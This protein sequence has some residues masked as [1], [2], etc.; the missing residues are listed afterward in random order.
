MS[1][2]DQHHRPGS[3]FQFQAQVVDPDVLVPGPLGGAP[4]HYCPADYFIGSTP[5]VACSSQMLGVGR[6][7]SGQTEKSGSFPYEVDRG[8]GGLYMARAGASVAAAFEPPR[9]LSSM[10]NVQRLSDRC[11]VCSL[12]KKS[13]ANALN[14]V[15]LDQGAGGHVH[16]RE[17][18]VTNN[19][20][21]LALNLGISF[22]CGG[23]PITSR[24]ENYALH[25]SPPAIDQKVEMMGLGKKVKAGGGDS[26]LM[27]YEFFPGKSNSGRCIFSEKLCFPAVEDQEAAAASGSASAVSR[28]GG[29]AGEA[30]NKDPNSVDLSLRLSY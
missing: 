25:G 30:S 26:L 19:R 12:K 5:P 9:E 23:N 24:E 17:R 13:N 15:M 22:N 18:P 1:Q 29:G 11:D 3:E 7:F 2:H 8:V 6:R 20:D 14:I 21:F 27:E 10:P 4:V 16:S 28:S